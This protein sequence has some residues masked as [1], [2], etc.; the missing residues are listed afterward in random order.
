MYNVMLRTANLKAK[1]NEYIDIGLWYK[2]A[3]TDL[4]IVVSKD[5]DGYY[6]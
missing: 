2:E 5:P 1:F 4:D 6:F 3:Q